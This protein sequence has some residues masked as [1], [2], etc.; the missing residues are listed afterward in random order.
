MY[1]LILVQNYKVK[2]ENSKDSNKIIYNASY[3]EKKTE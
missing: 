1:G 2:P 3:A